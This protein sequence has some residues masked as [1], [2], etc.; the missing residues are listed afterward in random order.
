VNVE[1]VNSGCTVSQFVTIPS[2]PAVPDIS[3]SVSD[4]SFCA[5]QTNGGAQVS[6][7]AGAVDEYEFTWYNDASL[8][9]GKIVYQA[10]GT[11]VLPPGG[12]RLDATKSGYML[13][14]AGQ[15]A[16]DQTFYVRAQRLPGTGPGAGCK[17]PA[18]Q[19]VIR[20]THVTPIATLSS[21]P[22]TSCDPLV[23]EGSVSI[24]T[25]T[26][27]TDGA[28]AGANYDYSISPDPNTVGTLA[29]QGGALSKAFIDLPENTYTTTVLNRV[30]GCL[31]QNDITVSPN[32]Y[33]IS[34]T[35]ALIN[36]KLVCNPDGDITVKEITIDRSVTAQAPLTFP[37]AGALAA[38]FEFRWFKGA[39]GTFTSGPPLEDDTGPAIIDGST[40]TVGSAAGE[41]NDPAPTLGAGIYYVV[42]RQL[43]G[44]GRFG[45][46]CESAPLMV[47]IK[48][49]SV[50][51]V[52]ALTPFSN[53][54]CDPATFEG[55][56]EVDVTDGSTV[57]AVPGPAFGYTYAWT[58][59]TAGCAAPNPSGNPY[60]GNSNLLSQVQDGVYEL[61]A[62]NTTTGCVSTKQTTV[63]QNTTPIFVQNVFSRAQRF[64]GP[65]GSLEVRGISYNDRAGATTNVTG[66]GLADFTFKWFKDGTAPG[67][68]VGG[69][70]AVLDSA[71]GNYPGIGADPDYYV[72][73]TRMN[74]SP[75]LNC[76]SVPFKVAIKDERKYPVI[77]L[78]PFSNTSCDPATFEGEIEVNV[79][80]GSLMPAVSGPA[81]GYTYTWSA[82][83]AGRAAPNPL[84]NPYD[85]N[86]NLFSQV[87]DGVYELRATNTT[88]GCA[89]TKQA[90][91]QQNTT[92]IFV[93][94][95]ISEA[96]LFCGP[97][98]SLEVRG[99]RYN[100]RTGA[101]TNVTGAGLAD[102]TFQWFKDGTA[103]G[104]TVGGATAVLDSAAGNY[105]GIGADPD[106]Y[107]VA[108]RMNNSPGLNCSSAPFRVA[109]MDKR[110]DPVVTF[111]TTANTTCN[112]SF[113]ASITVSAKTGGIGNDADY[114][115]VWNSNPGVPVS[116]ADVPAMAT[117]YTT[118]APDNIG[119]GTY[120]ATVT[121]LTTQCFTMASV[122]VQQNTIPVQIWDVTKI[123]QTDCAPFNGSIAIDSADPAQVSVPGAYTFVWEKAGVP[124]S[125]APLP[126]NM[127]AGIEA[128]VYTVTGTKSS[129]IAAG[130]TTAPFSVTVVDR[131][132][133][134]AIQL[135]AVANFACD[136][137][138][139]NGELSAV[140][141]EGTNAAAATDYNLEW[142]AGKNV[143]S[144]PVLGTSD[145]LTSR[146]DGDYTLVAVDNVS[147]N[148]GCDNL[149]TAAIGFDKT[150]FSVAVAPTA[151]NLCA[152]G[153]NGSIAV[154]GITEVRNGAST[155]AANL[156]LYDY[157]WSD[158]G[159]IL[160]PSTPMFTTGANAISNL[161]A[162]EY[163][164]R[165]RN[166]LGCVSTESAGVVQNLTVLPAITLDNFLNPTV[167]V[168]PETAG[169]LQVS[170]DNS[171]N[172][173]DYTFE[174]FEGPDD[175]GTLVEANNATLENIMYNQPT[176]YT[177]R[178]TNIATN[179]VSLDTYR[180]DVDTVQIEV[181]ASAV[182][183]TNCVVDDGNLFA[184]TLNGSG[185]L[186]N[187]EWYAG[188]AATGT[189]VYTTKQV[190]GV[191]IGQYTVIAVDPNHAFCTSTS[192]TTRVTD[193]R[194]LPPVVAV[195]RSPLTYCDPAKP[196]GVAYA[197]VDGDVVGYTFDWFQGSA[198]G[199]PVYTGPE[200]KGLTATTYVVR[201]TDAITGCE[202]TASIMIENDPVDVQEPTIVVV[203]NRTNCAVPD[204]ML[205]ASVNGNT[206]NYILQWYDG[207]TVSGAADEA[208]EFYRDLAEGSYT[209][210]ATD[211]ESGCV[212]DPVVGEVLP[213][214]EK[215]VFDVVTVPTN[216]EENIG[217]A[218]VNILNN[219][220]VSSIEWD[221]NGVQQTGARIAE[222]PK[223]E[224]SVI[225]TTFRQCSESKTFVIQPEVLVFNGISRNN[226]GQNDFFEIACIQDF[227]HNN[228]KIFD[229]A[230]TLVYEANGYDN[231]DVFFDGIS[232][233]GI[234][235]L[236][237]DLP[238]G[239]YFYIIDKRDGSKPVSGYLE[240]LSN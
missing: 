54:S 21:L 110:Q 53:T 159:G 191:P 127:L 117:S 81:F 63:Q 109:I 87:Q 55:E 161:L 202:Q 91:I 86:S 68:A 144:G 123:D 158:E 198:G 4:E 45:A 23:A 201:A 49:Q 40:L 221:I 152:P 218:A 31:A 164:V 193:E 178:V 106:Y 71:A 32:K 113:D 171:L 220:Q 59:L 57:P 222:L 238:D 200:I 61:R 78:T 72:V 233:R 56:I 224:F 187:Y 183:R 33:Q 154:T 211:K 79:K 18:R 17:S 5:P 129:G 7:S 215:P 6:A 176:E 212:S 60:D 132:E 143:T 74:D 170:A 124:V 83:T 174:W 15:G 179:C 203:S 138:Q 162:G 26:S 70:T 228:V 108:T 210:T 229:R 195:Q 122:T 225:V 11:G 73:A 181:I 75:G 104:N 163:H 121:N 150:S 125:P 98:G 66:A 145:M 146:P 2:Q 29:N 128:G 194:L 142:F 103:P 51:P 186:Y 167:C 189:P 28:V 25:T 99:I 230:G 3:V 148:R 47:E 185:A 166:A 84:G 197:S 147:P 34:L 173:S 58:A 9:A 101:T 155:P 36:N 8:A 62:T 93:Q 85:G 77:A 149:A 227:Q 20:D 182:G 111:G 41:Y 168:M 196:N 135:Q 46:N 100:D 24:S 156:T 39:A 42:A 16:G 38:N 217:K 130:C 205:S 240:L 37:A 80:D 96:Q 92:P 232:N 190:A 82:L 12:E 192:Y 188:P 141:F 136:P 177:V 10:N 139:A 216:C 214:E 30:S 236:G 67:N 115:I 35:D 1:E 120:T 107:V 131:T 184:T 133:R 105:P 19:V 235:L 44:A 180:F 112:N 88:T 208:G 140:I 102:F 226:D 97:S 126:D 153:Q 137:L 52:I 64:C 172:F 116:I 160:H 114:S 95:V 76:S 13:G 206:A 219:V 234:N 237:R 134:P 209:V 175:T 118:T 207:N 22:N 239:T 48:D 27:S 223:G 231:Q 213:M 69:A 50:D 151:Q 94:N 169:Y 165:V 14:A 89:S 119:P 157:Q 65:S 199:T 204:G 90:T 43:G